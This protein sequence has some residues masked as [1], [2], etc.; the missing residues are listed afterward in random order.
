MK[1]ITETELRE[2]YK[3]NPFE[4]Y[5]IVYPEKLT[6]AARQFL[7]D[8][9][10]KIIDS[11]DAKAGTIP[12]KNNATSGNCA[13]KAAMKEPEKGYLLM[14]RC[15]IVEEKPEAYTHLRGV[16]LVP[17]NCK[18]IKFRGML[19]ML[20]AH[21]IKTIVDLREDGRSTLADDIAILFEYT[22]K[23]MR[24]E[25][26]D[27]QLADIDYKGLSAD[28]IREYSHNPEKYLGV[29]HFIPDP[30]Y[31]KPMAVLN[32][33]R[34]QVRQTETAAVDAFYDEP[35][36][37]VGRQDIITALNRMSSLVYIIMCKTLKEENRT[38]D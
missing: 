26:L 20:E 29:R 22:K 36:K 19:D 30:K 33:L 37:T 27:E 13:V 21:F 16:K 2:I 1:V 5:T 38:S 35:T 7:T 34:T 23:V 4:T 3:K 18:R 10:I 24:A 11:R 8:R 17:K 9:K 28:E 31:G 12:A 6:P 32:L 15:E 14:D 25:V